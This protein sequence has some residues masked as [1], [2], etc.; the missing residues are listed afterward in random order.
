[1]A[2]MLLQSTSLLATPAPLEEA[3]TTHFT[4]GEDIAWYDGGIAWPQLGRYGSRNATAPDH[5]TTG[6]PG[7]GSVANV[8]TLA[9]LDEPAVN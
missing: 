5:S 7:S 8:T 4:G 3:A 1:M 6:G 9:T 2:L